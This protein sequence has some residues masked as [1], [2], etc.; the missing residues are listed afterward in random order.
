MRRGHGGA[1]AGATLRNP[2]LTMHQPWA[3]LLVHGIKRVEGRSWPSPVAGRR[4]LWIHAASK[5]PDPDTIR[6]MEDFYR[7]IY[8]VDGITQI[9]FPQHY[10][11]SRLLGCVEV[12]GCVTS[13]ELASWEYV[14]Q[15]VRLEALTDFCWLCENPQ[16]LVVPFEMRGYQG[17]YNLE[18]RIYEGA[19]RGLSHVQ[20]PLS[21][22]FPLPDPS[23]PL[24]LK[25]G[26]LK[27]DPSKSCSALEKTKT[28]SV[29]AAIA[30]ARA[31]ATQYSRKDH[32]V[33]TSSPT[34]GYRQNRADGSPGNDTPSVSSIV[35]NRPPYLQNQNLPSV[36]HNNIPNLRNQIL[37]SSVHISHP[38]LQNQHLPFTFQE[39]PIHLQNQNLP[40]NALDRGSFS[41]NQSPSSVVHH[42]P[43]Y[44]QNQNSEPRRS[45]R[46]QN[47]AP[48]RLV[49][50]ALR[51]LKQSSVSERGEQSQSVP[52][53]W[54]G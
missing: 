9:T 44:L 41:Q 3:S 47:G 31:A 20:G 5:V 1:G 29:T 22:K 33:A 35:Q 26:A 36:V 2:C 13:Q 18:R 12:V 6:A 49:A 16:K 17:V 30:G 14:P 53:S 21:V 45:P 10:P 54:P 39:T 48:S 46:L 52:K 24:S 42:G 34:Q 32:N 51:G 50:V 27:F 23:N 38:N 15:S 4:R 28:P 8:A 25:P 43:S 40:A 11:V 19:V 7:E 37:P